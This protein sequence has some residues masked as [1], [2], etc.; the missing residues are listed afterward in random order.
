MRGKRSKVV[1]GLPLWAVFIFVL[2][3]FFNGA[4]FIAIVFAM[5]RPETV[6]VPITGDV[7][8]GLHLQMFEA[9][10]AALGIG[11]AVFGFVGYQAIKEAA[12]R[13]ADEAARAAIGLDG[14][15]FRLRSTSAEEA[16][17]GDIPPEGEIQTEAEENL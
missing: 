9:F 3:S 8:I 10:L 15:T 14:G 11:M 17:L 4:I 2:V 6:P 5:W 12:E 16:M 1:I 13:K 7:A